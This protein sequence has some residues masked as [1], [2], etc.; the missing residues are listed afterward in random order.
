VEGLSG[1]S[2]ARGA[3]AHVLSGACALPRIPDRSGRG[4]RRRQPRRVSGRPRLPRSTRPGWQAS[5]A[6]HSGSRRTQTAFSSTLDHALRLHHARLLKGPNPILPKHGFR[7][8]SN[9]GDV[10]GDGR[11]DVGAL[12]IDRSE[13]HYNCGGDSPPCVQLFLAARLTAR[14]SSG[15][16][17]FD[18]RGDWVRVITA[19]PYLDHA[20]GWAGDWNHDGRS[21][22]FEADPAGVSIFALTRS[23]LRRHH[24]PAIAGPSASLAYEP[25]GLDL[26]H[27]GRAELIGAGI[28]NGRLALVIVSPR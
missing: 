28:H 27:D 15:R 13:A 4:R 11:P 14:S 22:M 24:L 17:L 23:G 10:D 18:C 8:A 21:D 7:A 1:T 2:T 16:L 9:V 3:G 26:T 20:F 5:P 6:V 25:I 12:D 19:G